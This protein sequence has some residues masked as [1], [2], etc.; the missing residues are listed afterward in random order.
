MR[1][2]A[3]L[4]QQVW[5]H[6]SA[7]PR[8]PLTSR[9]KA[10]TRKSPVDLLVV[11]ADHAVDRRLLDLDDRAAGVGQLDELLVHGGGQRH[12]QVAAVLVML[13]VHA[14]RDHLAGDRAELDGLARLAL[15]HFPHA[16]IFQRP[17]LHGP[18]TFGSTR[19]SSTSNMMSPAALSRLDAVRPRPDVVAA[20]G[21][22]AARSRRRTT[23][24]RRRRSRSAH[25]RR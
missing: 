3:G 11:D 4:P 24:A 7:L 15:R 6:T 12:D 17:A 22:R 23:S 14:G 13:V 16:R 8:R 20:R 25:R 10:S 2:A 9:L 18:V 5:H 1:W 19:V 21:P